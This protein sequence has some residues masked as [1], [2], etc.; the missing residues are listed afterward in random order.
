[1]PRLSSGRGHLR[2]RVKVTSRTGSVHL[3]FIEL[4]LLCVPRRSPYDSSLLSMKCRVRAAL[5]PQR[6]NFSLFF[7]KPSESLIRFLEMASQPMR[8]QRVRS[9]RY[10]SGKK[11]RGIWNKTEGRTH[12]IGDSSRQSKRV[13]GADH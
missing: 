8:H 9:C 3:R 6:R 1:M 2:S 12:S 10:V 4:L 5:F 13:Y 11:V 7:A